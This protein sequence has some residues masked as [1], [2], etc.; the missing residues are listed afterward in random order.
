MM[1]DIDEIVKALLVSPNFIAFQITSMFGALVAFHVIKMVVIIL[2][3]GVFDS[4]IWLLRRIK[5]ATKKRL[6]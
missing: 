1:N 4:L 3:D 6:A 5:R 2:I